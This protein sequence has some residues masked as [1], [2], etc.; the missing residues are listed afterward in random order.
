[1][2]FWELNFLISSYCIILSTSMDIP[3]KMCLSGPGLK[4][5]RSDNQEEE[6]LSPIPKRREK[7][8]KKKIR[9][10]PVDQSR[11]PRKNWTSSSDFAPFSSLG[12]NRK[13]NCERGRGALFGM[14]GPDRLGFDARLF[15]LTDAW[16][17]ICVGWYWLKSPRSLL[18]PSSSRL[19]SLF[20]RK[21]GWRHRL[22]FFDWSMPAQFLPLN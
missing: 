16:T 4:R 20:P 15:R 2:G 14:L 21:N 18:S 5:S 17:D 1:M 9:L 3:R 6:K 7:V 10:R 13:W 11:R 12:G 8:A 19:F 22:W